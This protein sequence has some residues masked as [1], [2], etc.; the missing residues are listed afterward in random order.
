[1]ERQL[2]APPQNVIAGKGEGL[3]LEPPRDGGIRRG[4]DTQAPVGRRVY[5]LISG[6]ADST[7]LNGIKR[8]LAPQDGASFG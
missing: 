3:A 7:K 5:T 1:M 4:R 8:R 6:D 2:G